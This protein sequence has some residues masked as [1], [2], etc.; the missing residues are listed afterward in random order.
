MLKAGFNIS[1]FVEL[2]KY[3][4]CQF[5]WCWIPGCIISFETKNSYNI[6]SLVL[7]NQ[8]QVRVWFAKLLFKN[9]KRNNKCLHIMVIHY[10]PYWTSFR[11]S[12]LEVFSK[13]HKIY[14]KKAVCGLQRDCYRCLDF[15]KL[16]TTPFLI[17]HLLWLLLVF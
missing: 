13:F 12:C 16:L 10:F 14:S 6:K 7:R 9:N 11:S 1:E 5:L 3:N 4:I 2:T 8:A 15:V 17:E